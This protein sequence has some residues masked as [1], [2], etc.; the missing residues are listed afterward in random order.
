MA[1]SAYTFK[2]LSNFPGEDEIVFP[3]GHIII[4]FFFFYNF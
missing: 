1:K 3:S 4:E 2:Y